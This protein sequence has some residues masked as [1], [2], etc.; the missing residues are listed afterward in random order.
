MIL[1]CCNKMG[2]KSVSMG[3]L[4]KCAEC[5]RAKCVCVVGAH[6]VELRC[7]HGDSS[8]GISLPAEPTFR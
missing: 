6:I 3:S 4:N 1:Q 8:L 7:E 2:G 5:V